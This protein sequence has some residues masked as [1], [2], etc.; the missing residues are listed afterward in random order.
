MGNAKQ[1]FSQFSTSNAKSSKA[2]APPVVP[3]SKPTPSMLVDHQNCGGFQ[4]SSLKD[5]ILSTGSPLSP[6][7]KTQLA[8]QRHTP[9]HIFPTNTL[10][11]GLVCNLFSLLLSWVQK[12]T[13]N[14]EAEI[15]GGVKDYSNLQKKECY[16]WFSNS[17]SVNY[18]RNYFENDDVMTS[19]FLLL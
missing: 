4:S 2:L 1:S 19:S 13:R 12:I 15:C 14:F 3:S 5:S 11:I 10:K 17:V 7:K 8:H 18:S 16:F 9:L 6:I